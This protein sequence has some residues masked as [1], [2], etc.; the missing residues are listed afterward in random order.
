[1]AAAP[2]W[3][4]GGTNSVAFQT[5]KLSAINVVIKREMLP[6]LVYDNPRTQLFTN[7]RFSGFTPEPTSVMMRGHVTAM[8]IPSR[9]MHAYTVVL[10][11]GMIEYSRDPNQLFT[12]IDNIITNA[13]ESI[14]NAVPSHILGQLCESN[15]FC[16]ECYS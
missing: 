7:W 11:S 5:D 16:E 8:H 10:N 2:T 14:I 6:A 12:H 13:V 3:Q 1:M 15:P 4:L 9:Q